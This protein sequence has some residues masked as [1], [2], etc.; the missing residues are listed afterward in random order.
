MLQLPSEG[1]WLCQLVERHSA[2]TLRQQS[3]AASQ[4]EAGHQQRCPMMSTTT[5]YA[6]QAASGAVGRTPVP[7]QQ[8]GKGHGLGEAGGPVERLVS[9]RLSALFPIC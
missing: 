3:L 5:N 1:F 2:A 6:P 7:R 4:V 8:R 9:S